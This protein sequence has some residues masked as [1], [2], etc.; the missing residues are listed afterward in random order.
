MYRSR[1]LIETF[2]R[3][4]KQSLS[5]KSFLSTTRNAVEVRIWTALITMLFGDCCGGFSLNSFAA[6]Q[7]L[8]VFGKGQTSGIWA[9]SK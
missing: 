7:I 2:F 3:N 5:I 4:L 8:S 1:W 9:P 6:E